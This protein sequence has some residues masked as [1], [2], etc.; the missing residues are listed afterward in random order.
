MSDLKNQ[1]TQH[2]K[3]SSFIFQAHG[4]TYRRHVSIISWSTRRR[5]FEGLVG[6]KSLLGN[7]EKPF[8][9]DPLNK[10]RV[11]KNEMRVAWARTL[12]DLTALYIAYNSI[13]SH[14]GGVT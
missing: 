3:N 1:C 10:T 13:I 11:E 5:T 12:K 2:R 4:W 8:Y 6:Q 14:A 7:L 9:V